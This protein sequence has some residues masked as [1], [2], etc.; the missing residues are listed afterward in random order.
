MA[1]RFMLRLKFADGTTKLCGPYVN[2]R[3]AKAAKQRLLHDDDLRFDRTTIR[4]VPAPP[5]A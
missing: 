5:A 1:T 4:I 3:L 2:R